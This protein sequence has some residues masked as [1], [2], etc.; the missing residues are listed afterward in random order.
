MNDTQTRRMY[1]WAEIEPRK[2]VVAGATGTWRLIYHVGEYGIDD[3]ARILIANRFASDMGRP[4][5]ENPDGPN[6]ITAETTGKARVRLSYNPKGYVRPWWKTTVVEVYEGYLE[7]GDTITVTY[8]DRSRGSPGIE[9]QT[10]CEDSYEFKVL[11]DPFGT[12]QPTEV[13]SSPTL[14]I[15]SGEPAKMV[16]LIPTLITIGESFPLVV[17]IEDLWGN[18]CHSYRGRVE[19][20]GSKSLKVSVDRYSFS[21]EDRGTRRFEG[22]TAEQPGPCVISVWDPEAGLNAQSNSALVLEEK[23][24]Y[25]AYWSDL[26]GQSEET[27]GTNTVDDYFKFARDV[28]ALDFCSHQGNDFQITKRVWT[29]IRRTVRKYHAPGR[30]VTFLGYEWSGNTLAGGDHN[31]YYLEDDEP[32]HRSG[33]AQIPDRSDLA[34]DRYPLTRLY[35]E[36]RGKKAMVVPHVGGR[37]AD[38]QYHDPDL[39][40]L[41]EIYSEWGEFEWFLEEAIERGY[42]VGFIAGSDDHKGRPGAANPGR[43]TFGVYGGL[44]C[45]Y[46][47]ELTRE[48]IWEA[49][50]SRRCYATTGQRILLRSFVDGHWMGEEFEI[51]RAPKIE[52]EVLGT[53]PIERV[54]VVRNRTTIFQFPSQVRRMSDVVRVAWG[55]A[56]VKGRERTATWDGWLSLDRGSILEAKGYTL[57]SQAEEVRQEGDRRVSWASSTAGD[58]DGVILKLDAPRETVLT[59]NSPLITF[60]VPLSEVFRAL[61]VRDVGG[62][63]LKVRVEMLPVGTGTKY[64]RFTFLDQGIL[65]G[66]SAYYVRVLQ[67]DGGKAWSSPTYVQY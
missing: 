61:V 19:I 53:S 40:P 55:G 34:S 47:K 9:M 6:Y 10:F 39:E 57:D 24:E 67:G 29:K 45:V 22:I 28:A 15:I 21:K 64:V 25:R 32:M 60:S 7:T 52:V 23:P 56:K 12:G 5:T 46:A 4:Q 27:I 65:R 2:P 54:D 33:H 11:V 35:D 38:L 51:G 66:L 43:S 59:F 42:K 1:G 26:H 13:P 37:Y 62:L 41:V 58:D 17:R 30:F 20:R 63:G 8:G 49:F 50:F 44:T 16:A 14:K 48:A 3:G 31:V 36:L 18:P